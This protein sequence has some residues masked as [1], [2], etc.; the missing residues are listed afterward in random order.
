LFLAAAV[1]ALPLAVLLAPAHFLAVLVTNRKCVSTI[2]RSG[3]AAGIICMLLYSPFLKTAGNEFTSSGRPS[4]EYGRFIV[5]SFAGTLGFPPP[6]TP[7]LGAA[8]GLGVIFG[9]LLRGRTLPSLQPTLIS[10]TAVSLFALVLPLFQPEAGEVRAICWLMPLFGLA[11][12]AFLWPIADSQP[13]H[14]AAAAVGAVLSLA[15]GLIWVWRVPSQPIRE[16]I[17]F[18]ASRSGSMKRVVGVGMA[19]AEG[20]VLYGGLTQVAYDLNALAELEKAADSPVLVV[21]Y[22][23]F[24]RRD[25]IELWRHI[26]AG[27]KV[28]RHIEGRVAG[29]NV[30]V[31]R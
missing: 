21:F 17:D 25:Q 18:A 11:M 7:W 26:Q 5:E 16:A 8:L 22:E 1:Y 19:S 4:I 30:Y 23:D 13:R 14:Y 31:R 28:E 6:G 24:L 3:L 20:R 29:A 10:Y 12:T 27:Y 15:P 9:G 2:L